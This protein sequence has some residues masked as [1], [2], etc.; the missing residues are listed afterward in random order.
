MNNNK[1]ILLILAILA[2]ALYGSSMNMVTTDKEI[3]AFPGETITIDW[4]YIYT[5][6]DLFGSPNNAAISIRPMDGNTDWNYRKILWEGTMEANQHYTGE[7]S[8]KVPD[9]PGYYYYDI[10]VCVWWDEAQEYGTL[11]NGGYTLTVHVQNLEELSLWEK[12]KMIINM[13]ITWL[14]GGQ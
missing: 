4:D 14:T 2:V 13:I 10:E 7:G 5:E 11:S 1:F 9:T 6:Y 3:S 12:I 8:F